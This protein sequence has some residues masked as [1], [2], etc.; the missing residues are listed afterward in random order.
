MTFLDVNAC[1]QPRDITTIQFHQKF[2]QYYDSGGAK[3]FL[4]NTQLLTKTRQNAGQV[5]IPGWRLGSKRLEAVKAVALDGK[6][7]EG[8]VSISSWCSWLLGQCLRWG[9]DQTLPAGPHLRISSPRR[10]MGARRPQSVSPVK[11]WLAHQRAPS[12]GLALGEIRERDELAT[13]VSV[14]GLCVWSHARQPTNSMHRRK[15]TPVCLQARSHCWVSSVIW[16]DLWIAGLS[17]TPRVFIL[18]ICIY[19]L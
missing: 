7:G 10:F 8:T 17:A 18:C 19:I 14:A 1:Q 2:W 6:P 5:Q 4:S 13:V 9:L 16:G 11:A 15:S 12:A 3:P